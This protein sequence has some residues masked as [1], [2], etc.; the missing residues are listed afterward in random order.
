LIGRTYWPSLLV[1]RLVVAGVRADE[2]RTAPDMKKEVTLLDVVEEIRAIP[3][4]TSNFAFDIEDVGLG[5]GPLE[6]RE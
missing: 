3:T 5:A 1:Y 6:R 4:L 2:L